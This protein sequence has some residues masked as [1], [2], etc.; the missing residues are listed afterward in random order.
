MKPNINTTPKIQQK[1]KNFL[2][3]DALAKSFAEKYA[4]PSAANIIKKILQ[5]TPQV[6]VNFNKMKLTIK[7]I[8]A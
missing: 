4:S 5:R 3:L 8:V 6:C 2:I 7:V 1:I